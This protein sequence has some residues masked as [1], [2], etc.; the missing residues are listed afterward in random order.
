M[1]LLY[2]IG[3]T[4][5][6][7]TDT[8]S[9]AVNKIQAGNLKV[10]IV[11]EAG[12][13]IK[14]DMI[15]F[16]DREGNHDNILWEPGATFETTG[17][18]IKNAGNLAL[19]YKLALSGISGDSKLLKV[20]KFSVVNAV[21]ETIDM[22]TY[23]GNLK[24][25]TLS[26]TLYIKGEMDKN[27]GNEYQGL[28]INGIGITVYATQDTVENDSYDNQYDNEAKFP[29]GTGTQSDPYQI[30]DAATLSNIKNNGTYTYY[31]IADGVKEIDCSNISW[32]NLYGEFDGNGATLKNLKKSL[33]H[34]VG[35]GKNA[36][37]TT[38]LKNFT[39]V[40]NTPNSLVF[41][42]SGT[43]TE[44][45]NV[46]V[47]GYMEGTWNMAAFANY[48]TKNNDS[49]GYDYTVSFV[50]CACDATIVSKGNNSAAILVGHTYSGAGKATIKLD[51]ATDKGI[52]GAK[53]IAKPNPGVIG[54]KYYGGRGG[55]EKGYVDGDTTENN[56]YNI[57]A[58]TV[59]NPTNNEGTYSVVKAENAAKVKVNM[60]AQLTAYTNGTPDKNKDGITFS[61]GVTDGVN[62]NDLLSGKNIESVKI[63]NDS[64][65]DDTCK[66]TLENGTLTVY[67]NRTD[68]Y[69][70]G[71]LFI[72]VSQYDKDGVLVSVGELTVAEKDDVNGSWTIK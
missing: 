59:A 27:A 32:L 67:T 31:K 22:D 33:F 6:W 58:L 49:T 23:E 19:K 25:G 55:G 28:S 38:V 8:A 40:M 65:R 44:F 7:F 41:N 47:S 26:D 51:A 70:T 3:T 64:Q 36:D 57:T 56:S 21:G 17:F 50:N 5:A 9:T 62:Y 52:N 14:N 34:N 35:N 63:V 66:Y 18:M 29:I 15:Y 46:K 42:I 13:S 12:T 45:N 60:N 69:V 20:I 37:E 61:L 10:D 2:A 11:N 68:N 30:H 39:A 16:V 54:F 4:F 43:K 24:K 53:L 1:R 48:G 71:K 72:T